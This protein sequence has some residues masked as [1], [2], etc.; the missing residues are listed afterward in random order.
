MMNNN[1]F[2]IHRVFGTIV[3]QKNFSAGEIFSFPV[4]ESFALTD[5]RVSDNK[6]LYYLHTGTSGATSLSEHSTDRTLHVKGVI[7]GVQEDGS[8]L[9]VRRVPDASTMSV[10]IL[11][12]G[13]YTA[14]EDAEW[15]CI[16]AETN[17]LNKRA[18]KTQFFFLKSGASTTLALGTKLLV[19]GGD[20]QIDGT[21][22]GSGKA[23]ELVTAPKTA[24]AL[25][26]CY[27][28]LFE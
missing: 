17:R 23:V 21:V 15:W 27:G 3:H 25:S 22:F 13:T 5:A 9:P 24:A 14:E 11:P 8:P 16:N 19:C 18:K 1:G 10:T 20:L 28:F 6:V 12:P 26:D 7:T 4:G 2:K